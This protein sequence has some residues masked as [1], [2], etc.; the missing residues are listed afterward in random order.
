[1]SNV[2]YFNGQRKTGGDSMAT[3]MREKKRQDIKRESKTVLKEKK[4]LGAKRKKE[5][6]RIAEAVTSKSISVVVSRIVSKLAPKYTLLKEPCVDISSIVKKD[7]FK[8]KFMDMPI[9]T[10]GCILVNDRKWGIKKERFIIVNENLSIPE[11][12]DEDDIIF[13][14]RRFITAHE[15]G[16]YI[17]HKPQNEPLYA[18]RKSNNENRLNEEIEAEYFARCLLMPERSF[19]SFYEGL[20]LFGNDDEEYTITMLSN[21]FKVSKNK[22]RIR[23]EELLDI[24]Q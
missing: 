4:E 23:L 7:K 20:N 3:A 18:H 1:M 22:V 10:T 17:L 15:F 16:H 19:I 12:N 13:K 11:D 9:D 6:E 5:I 14:K 24:S 21:L 2:I 8:I